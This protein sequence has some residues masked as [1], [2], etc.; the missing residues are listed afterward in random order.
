MR[1][2]QFSIPNA[3][4]G[5]AKVE[6]LVRL[7]EDVLTAEFEARSSTV[8]SVGE[9]ARAFCCWLPDVQTK[10]E[11]SRRLKPGVNEVR[12]PVSELDAVMFSK[13]LFGS[14]M[15]IKARSMN[16]V[17]EV[18]GSRRGAITMKFS[19]KDS[20]DAQRLASELAVKISEHQL[21]RLDTEFERLNA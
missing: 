9:I 3:Y 17:S 20:T 10:S 21:E 15:T 13:R 2:I 14:E 16:V 5:F 4:E 6:G 7:E 19:R 1:S 8:S 18:P 12:I 11:V